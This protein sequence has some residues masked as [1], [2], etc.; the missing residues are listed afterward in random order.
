MD[1]EIVCKAADTAKYKI[2]ESEKVSALWCNGSTFT[3]QV[4]D[5]GS[6]PGGAMTIQKAQ[7]IQTKVEIQEPKLK[8]L[9]SLNLGQVNNILQRNQSP[10]RNER[11][12]MPKRTTVNQP[13]RLF[14]PMDPMY[15]TGDMDT[16]VN[17]SKRKG[18]KAVKAYEVQVHYDFKK[19]MDHHQLTKNSSEQRQ[20]IIIMNDHLISEPTQLDEEFNDLFA[21]VID[22]Q[23]VNS[24]PLMATL[25]LRQGPTVS[26]AL[27]PITEEEV[28]LVIQTFPGKKTSDINFVSCG[29]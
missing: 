15:Q 20:L 25:Q 27:A 9:R 13:N 29:S 7:V 28:V 6:T 18:I 1:Q 23:P 10:S 12:Q 3:W 21:H 2:I 26:M 4:R 24:G 16:G 8:N 11:L 19:V 17:W 5:P 14:G 22:Q